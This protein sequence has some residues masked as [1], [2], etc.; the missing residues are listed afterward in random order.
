MLFTRRTRSGI[1]NYPVLHRR[2]HLVVSAAALVFVCTAPTAAFPDKAPCD[3]AIASN[4]LNG[5]LGYQERSKDQ[6]ENGEEPYCEGL[7]KRD[8]AAGVSVKFTVLTVQLHSNP[9]PPEVRASGSQE[10][11]P[12]AWSVTWPYMGQPTRI[13]GFHVREDVRYRL[14]AEER[15][16]LTPDHGAEPRPDGAAGPKREEFKWSTQVIREA[17]KQYSFPWEGIR[18]AVSTQSEGAGPRYVPV[19]F[20]PTDEPRTKDIDFNTL[21]VVVACSQNVKP[22]SATLTSSDG[23]VKDLKGSQVQK[24]IGPTPLGAFRLPF[25]WEKDHGDWVLEFQYKR[26]SRVQ[27]APPIRLYVPPPDFIRWAERH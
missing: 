12:T 16:P 23:R 20:N 9:V 6:Q 3:E 8:V 14:D 21:C 13:Q 24:S 5:D 18:L 10:Y 1:Q 4:K 22:I 27:A 15:T 26:G 25:D 7:Y 2:I 19:V 11:R 17:C